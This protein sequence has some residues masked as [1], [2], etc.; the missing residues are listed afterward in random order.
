MNSFLN[1]IYSL[2]VKN[3]QYTQAKLFDK[4]QI[5]IMLSFF[6]FIITNM[7]NNFSEFHYISV[8]FSELVG[9]KFIIND[10]LH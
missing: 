6:I 10:F 3:L 2:W 4:D 1:N 8:T 9:D 5:L 7:T